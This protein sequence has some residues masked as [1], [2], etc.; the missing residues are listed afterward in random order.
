MVVC[1][2]EGIAKRSLIKEIRKRTKNMVGFSV[3]SQG[4]HG[5]LTRSD[6]N[7]VRECWFLHQTGLLR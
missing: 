1:L 4:H 2:K 3:V 5:Y 6:R 7:F